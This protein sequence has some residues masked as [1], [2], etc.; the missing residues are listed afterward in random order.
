MQPK[1][2]LHSLMNE[3][4]STPVIS[5]YEKEKEKKDT[6]TRHCNVNKFKRKFKF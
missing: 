4:L 5:M 2:M 3:K 1:I 6:L